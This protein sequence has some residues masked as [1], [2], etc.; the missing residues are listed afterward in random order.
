MDLKVEIYP[1][2]RLYFKIEITTNHWQLSHM[3][4][5]EFKHRQWR[6]TASSQ[7]QRLGLLSHQGRCKAKLYNYVLVVRALISYTHLYVLSL[8]SIRRMNVIYMGR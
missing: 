8:Y 6:E 2:P 7:R 3:P 4:R 1:I 5:L